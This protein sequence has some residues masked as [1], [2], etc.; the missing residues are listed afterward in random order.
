MISFA[1]DR[2]ANVRT[3]IDLTTKRSPSPLLVNKK[4]KRREPDTS[5]EPFNI[6]SVATS[7]RFQ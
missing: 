6:I 1:N 5:G 3:S 7:S 4:I 2:V